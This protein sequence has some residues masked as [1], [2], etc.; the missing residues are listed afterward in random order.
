MPDPDA[1]Y[2]I[3]ITGIAASSADVTGFIAQMENSSYFSFVVPG[4]LEHAK[5]SAATKFQI[6]CYVNNYV[7]E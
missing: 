4:L 7:T 5:D 3:H 1:Q 2:K 6:S